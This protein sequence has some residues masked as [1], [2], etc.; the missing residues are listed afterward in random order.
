MR[1]V[2]LEN[3]KVGH[4]SN[5]TMIRFAMVATSGCRWSSVEKRDQMSKMNSSSSLFL[6]SSS[7]LSSSST[8]SGSRG[9][10]YSSK[11]AI[12]SLKRSPQ[13]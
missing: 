6:N 13:S 5:L 3:A 4:V 10:H 7:S 8:Y 2:G 1:D 9:G 11:S 12:F